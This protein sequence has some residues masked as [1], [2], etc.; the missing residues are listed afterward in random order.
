MRS[1]EGLLCP[2]SCAIPLL[3]EDSRKPQCQVSPG[4]K[5]MARLKAVTK[6]SGT[7]R[8]MN[9]RFTSDP[10]HSASPYEVSGTA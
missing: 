3:S 8:V 4:L 10:K 9:G 7:S 1:G 5:T 2:K 6:A